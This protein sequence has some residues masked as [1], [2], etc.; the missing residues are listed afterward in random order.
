MKLENVESS[1]IAVTRIGYEV[2]E[3]LYIVQND[4]EFSQREQRSLGHNRTLV[5]VEDLA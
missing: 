1:G 2:L 5:V 3:K 4:N